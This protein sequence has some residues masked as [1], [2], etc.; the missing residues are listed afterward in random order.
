MTTEV[1]DKPQ[2]KKKDFQTDQAVRWCPGCGDYAILTAMQNTL[3]KL[4]KKKEDFVFISGIGCSSRFPYYMN[5]Y[6]FHTIHGRAPAIATGTKVTNPD[7]DVWVISG[8]GDSYSIGGNHFIHCIRRN[9]SLKYIIFNNEIYGLTKGQYSPTSGEGLVTKSTPYGSLDRPFN[10]ATLALGAGCT[11]YA[12]VADTSP[13]EMTAVFEE[14][15]KHKGTAIVEIL[16]NCV[17]FN[18]GVHKN[19]TERETRDDHQLKLEAGKPMIFG[20]DGNKGIVIEGLKPKVVTIGEDGVTE[21]DIVVHDPSNPDP[22]MAFLLA[23]MHLPEFPVPMGVYRSVQDVATYEEQVETQVKDVM[24][25]QKPDLQGLLTG[26]ST[27][28]VK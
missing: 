10:P 18:D 8:D 25:K 24:A 26:K 17:I 13:K 22:T 5:T 1:Q 7:L 21:A 6:G 3:P 9:V 4:G 2:Y 12:R 16:Q 23:Q 27:W 19:V 15:A 20:K 14:A 11:F 28:T